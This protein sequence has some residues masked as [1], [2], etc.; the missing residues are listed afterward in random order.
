MIDQVGD[1]IVAADFARSDAM[2][3]DTLKVSH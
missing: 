3:A 2:D 1:G